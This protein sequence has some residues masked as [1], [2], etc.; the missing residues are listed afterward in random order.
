MTYKR[1]AKFIDEAIIAIMQHSSLD[2]KD[3][4]K[5][6]SK[7]MGKIFIKL[8]KLILNDH[9]KRVKNILQSLKET[10]LSLGK[11]HTIFQEQC[12]TISQFNTVYKKAFKINR[13]GQI[14]ES[15]A[16]EDGNLVDF[17]DTSGSNDDDESDDDD[18]SGSDNHGNP[19]EN[20]GNSR[21]SNDDDE[22]E[23]DNHGNS[24]DNHGNSGSSND[25]DDDDDDDE[26]G[27][28]NHGRW[29]SS[30]D[31]DESESNNDESFLQ[32]KRKRKN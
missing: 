19:G 2:L 8:H 29:E 21:S 15:D 7:L 9:N 5:Q 17:I 11:D 12:K 32:R 13:K 3:S 30:N 23:S 31:D 14:T 26:S 27:S 24:G 25:D 10:I 6:K 22:S 1:E 4:T 20:H 28:D 18:E 16:D